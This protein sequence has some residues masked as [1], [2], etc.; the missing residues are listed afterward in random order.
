M[1]E[2]YISYIME[3]IKANVDLPL[4]WVTLVDFGYPV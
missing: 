4:E 2:I 1:F 3:F